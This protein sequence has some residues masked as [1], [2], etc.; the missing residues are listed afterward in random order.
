MFDPENRFTNT[1]SQPLIE[2][3]KRK[4]VIIVWIIIFTLIAGSIIFFSWKKPNSPVVTT[5]HS[6][7]TNAL[8]DQTQTTSNQIVN[9][10][11]VNT[12]T[13]AQGTPAQTKNPDDYDAKKYFNITIDRYCTT[14]RERELARLINEYRKTKGLPSIAVSKSLSYLEKIHSIDLME[15]QPAVGKCTG[16]SWSD[17]GNWSSC[18]YTLPPGPGDS[19]CVQRKTSEITNLSGSV[20][21]ISYGVPVGKTD[22]RSENIY[23]ALQ[24]LDGWQKSKGHNQTIINEGDAKWFTWKSVGVSIYKESPNVMFSVT[25][26]PAGESV[27]CSANDFALCD[28]IQNENLKNEC[29]FEKSVAHNDAQICKQISDGAYR[30]DCYYNIVLLNNGYASCDNNDW[31][32]KQKCQ[33]RVERSVCDQITFDAFLR[34]ECYFANARF[35]QA[36]KFCANIQT[37]D[38]KDQCYI[39]ISRV[40]K[41]ADVCPLLTKEIMRD[42][43]YWNIAQNAIDLSVCS[44]IKSESTQKSCIRSTCKLI[45]YDQQKNYS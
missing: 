40:G 22:L 27:Y 14:D 36:S 31:S 26:D 9:A 35:D 44:L 6:D 23:D 28:N 41:S 19:E 29:F 15:N 8:M 3:S 16:H 34:D 20:A 17:K 12:N 43:C 33:E 10:P 4:Q 38:T 11:A 18:C 39:F 2:K 13:P 45:P 37:V 42:S 32:N 7:A 30:S 1:N 21:E 5:N 24:A 25:D